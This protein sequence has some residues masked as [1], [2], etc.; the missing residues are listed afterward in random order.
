M[1]EREVETC[2]DAMRWERRNKIEVAIETKKK[3]NR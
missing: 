3:S 1:V 2:C